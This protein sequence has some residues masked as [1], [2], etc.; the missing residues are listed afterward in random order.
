MTFDLLDCDLIT[1]TK[2]GI[3]FIISSEVSVISEQIYQIK[4]D[5][6]DKKICS[7]MLVLQTNIFQFID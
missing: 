2:S 3:F 1:L 7:R 5:Q 6:F 4:T